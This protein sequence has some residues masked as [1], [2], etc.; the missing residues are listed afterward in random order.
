MG[1][2]FRCFSGIFHHAPCTCAPG[3]A[4]PENALVHTHA[5]A[6]SP[7]KILGF[8]ANFLPWPLRATTLSPRKRC[9]TT[10]RELA[11]ERS[12]H[13]PD[14]LLADQEILPRYVARSRPCA[15]DK[16]G[17]RNT[18]DLAIQHCS[19]TTTRTVSAVGGA[20]LPGAVRSTSPLRSFS[21][22]LPCRVP[23]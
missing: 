15:T 16:R 3:R 23:M 18:H 22:S 12:T 5:Y 1:E 2:I 20:L 19:T 11:T 21:I 7:F 6:I 9:A 14:I 8:S 17:K 13:V 10:C 4:G